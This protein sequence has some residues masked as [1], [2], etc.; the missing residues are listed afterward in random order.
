MGVPPNHSNFN[1]SF[2]YK[3]TILGYPHLWKPS[4]GGFPFLG[5]P[6]S[7]E[8]DRNSQRLDGD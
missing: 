5:D 7:I 4:Y 1:G 8:W 2:P 6:P 3:P